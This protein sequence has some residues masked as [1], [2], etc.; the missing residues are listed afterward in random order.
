MRRSTDRKCKSFRT[1]VLAL[2]LDTAS[3]YSK[4]KIGGGV[5]RILSV[6][7]LGGRWY[8]AVYYYIHPQIPCIFHPSRIK[9]TGC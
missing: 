2:P 4:T 9:P 1:V 6:R 3:S 7:L 5:R 8:P